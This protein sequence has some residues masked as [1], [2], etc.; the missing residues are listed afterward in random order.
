M[1]RLRP[2]AAVTPVPEDVDEFLFAGILK[3]EEYRS[4]SNVRPYRLKVPASAEIIIEG[5]IRH[6]E[7]EMEGPFGD[8]TGYYNAAEPFPVFHCEGYYPQEEPH[9]HDDDNRASSEGGRRNR[10]GA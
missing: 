6:G 4:S 9:L 3:E 10:D 2:L 1:N 5:E 8:H 7:T